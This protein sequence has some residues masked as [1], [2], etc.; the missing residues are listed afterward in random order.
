MLPTLLI[1]AL[2]EDEPA[3]LQGIDSIGAAAARPVL[4]GDRDRAARAAGGDSPSDAR[5]QLR[6]ALAA[7]PRWGPAGTIAGHAV[8]TVGLALVIRPAPVDL[9]VYV[10]LGGGVGALK[11][12]VA[13]FGGGGFLV[14]VV[15]AALVSAIAFFAHGGDEAASLRLIIPPLVTFLPG[16]LLTIG[17]VDLAMGDTITGASRFIAGLLQLSL[18]GIG[19]VVG[20]E[21]IGN[22]HAGPV[23]GDAASQLGEWSPWLGV[24][25]FGIGEFVYASRPRGSLPW[26]LVVLFT[27]WIGQ[28]VGELLVGSTLSGFV[29]AAAMVPAA[30]LVARVRRAPPAH[31]MFL[32]AFW[33]LVP[34]T[35]GLIGITELVGGT[36]AQSGTENFVTALVATGSVA[37]GILVGTMIVRAA[38]AARHVAARSSPSAAHLRVP[39]RR[40]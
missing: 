5:A 23:A 40:L 26:L 20:A 10:M 1:V 22:P 12:W 7:P 21:L 24:L 33:L 34:G 36:H 4:G 17:M 2:D 18:L 9:W 39:N 19:I 27:A 13:R 8:L 14:A 3:G 11:A 25:V 16:G 37:L 32:P 29:G 15:A 35:I 31:V 28:F 38:R 30:H 6:R